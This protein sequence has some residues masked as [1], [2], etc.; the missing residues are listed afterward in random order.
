MPYEKLTYNNHDQS[1]HISFRKKSGHF[2]MPHNHFHNAYEIYYLLSGER[3]Y[4][5]K[6]RTFKTEKGDLV[7][8][9]P[10]DLHKTLDAGVAE[11]QRFLVIFKS[12][13]FGYEN[14]AVEDLLSFIFRQDNPV[15]RLGKKE[16]SSIEGIFSVIAKEINS[17]ATGCEASIQ[18]QFLQLLVYA[19]RY[20]E[21]YVSSS[22]DHPSQM[23]KMV[24]E[25]V[26]YIN[27]HYREQ[28]TLSNVSSKFYI[29][30]YHLSR[31]FKKATGFSFTEFINSVRI[32]EAQ[33]LLRD[34]DS[35]IINVA[36][37][38]GF[39]SISHF[40]RVFKEVTGT[41]PLQYRKTKD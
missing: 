37:E 3:Y 6:N 41:S 4:F 32:K 21:Q 26:N 30:R 40:C 9:N 5:T 27:A 20:Y 11:H 15:L 14:K 16:Q 7:F 22:F 1:F 12:S 39:G 29:S 35:K 8:I 10:Y 23:H 18:A 31:V 36:E 28:L 33:T 34:R 25:V 24:S 38:V 2:S 17:Q 13:Y 19:S